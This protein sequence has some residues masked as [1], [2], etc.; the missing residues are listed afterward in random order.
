MRSAVLF[1]LLAGCASHSRPASI[2]TDGAW[3]RRYAASRDDVYH[4]AMAAFTARGWSIEHANP[5]SGS[6]QAKSAVMTTS[7][8]FFGKLLRYT[9]ARIDIEGEAGGTRLRLKMIRTREPEGAGRRPNNDRVV[10]DEALHNT[11]LDD[12]VDRIRSK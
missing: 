7:V 3:V 6:F 5:L 4:A 2:E 12:I 10:E 1:F 9:L 8:P 11:L